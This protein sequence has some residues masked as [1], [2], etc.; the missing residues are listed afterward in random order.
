MKDEPRTP[1]SAP[2]PAAVLSTNQARQGETTG[3]IRYV[4]AVS[5]ALAIVAMVV[6]YIII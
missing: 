5:T 4:L 1:P 6:A 2:E 3:R